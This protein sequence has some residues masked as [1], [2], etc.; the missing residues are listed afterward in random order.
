[1]TIIQKQ[2]LL[3]YLGYY[4]GAVDGIWGPRSRQATIDFQNRH[5]LEADGSFGPATEESILRALTGGDGVSGDFWDGIRFF[6][7]EEFRCR[8]GGKFCGGFPAEPSE[9]LVRLADRVRQHFGAP[10][11]VSSGLR[12]PTHNRNVGGVANSRHLRGLAMDMS[13]AGRTPQEVL[14]FLQTQPE[15]HYA[16]AID[17]AFLHMDVEEV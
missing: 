5:A 6:K 16:Y 12:C 10:I 1:M 15:T 9:R 4:T 2:C 11:T 14:S 8:C 3:R 17:S 7:K 13:V